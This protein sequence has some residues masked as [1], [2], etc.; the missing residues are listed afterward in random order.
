[1]SIQW[2]VEWW[3]LRGLG[4]PQGTGMVMSMDL[5]HCHVIGI[6]LTTPAVHMGFSGITIALFT[7]IPLPHYICY[8][9]LSLIDEWLREFGFM[10]ACFVMLCIKIAGLA[11]IVASNCVSVQ[12]CLVCDMFS[13]WSCQYHLKPYFWRVP[14]ILELSLYLK[15]W[16][17]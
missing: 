15:I 11:V 1:M 2:I 9:N 12:L 6:L 8:Y 16:F 4:L 14:I 3:T 13:M 10:V 17:C 7:S 5:N